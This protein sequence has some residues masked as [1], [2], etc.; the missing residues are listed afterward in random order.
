MTGFETIVEQAAI[1]WFQDLGYDFVTGPTLAPDGEAPERADYKA[2]LLEDRF[3]AALARINPH[4]PPDALEQV[5]R[6]ILRGQTGSLDEDNVAFHRHLIHGVEL[7]VRRG[8]EDRGD[9]AWL[10]DFEHPAKNDWLVVNQL[11]IH[12]PKHNRRP[13]VVVYLNG[14]PIAVLELKNPEDQNA[15]LRSAW[16]QLQTY[17]EQVP[18]LFR[19]N[20]IL[21]LSDGTDAKVGSFTAGFERFG[22]WRTVDGKGLAPDAAPKLEVAIRGL[23]DKAR[24]LDYLRHFI[25]CET[26]DRLEKKIG[27][28]H[29]YWAVNK[30]VAA[31]VR[32]AS[33]KDDHRIGV[34]WHTQG[35]G[36]SISMV[37]YAGKVIREPAMQ[38]PTLVVLTDRNDLDGQLFAQFAAAQDLLRTVPEQATSREH[39][40]ELLKVASGGIVFTTLQKFGTAKGERM[41]E[42]SGR[43]NIVVV[44]DEAHRS[45]Y[46]FV[47]GLARNLRDALPNASFLGFTGT[48]IEADD[49]STAAVFGDYVDTYTISQAVADG[50]TVPIYY[51]ARL[52]RIELP[53]AE[54]P[55]LD[56][57]FDEITE[58]E[59]EATKGKL[60]TNWAKLE[61]VVGAERRVQLIAK[62]IV[63]HWERR[64]EIL[65]GKAMIVGMSRRICVDLYRAIVALRPDWH[66]PDDGAGRIK[67][68][69]T[70][71]ATDPEEFRPHVRNKP[72]QKAIEKRF[73]DPKDDL[74]L[75][76][77][78]DMWLTGFDVP[79]AHTLYLDKPMQGHSLMQAIARVNRVFR[80]KPSGLVVDYLGLAEQLRRAVG[81]YGGRS[82][83]RPG[84]P[85]EEALVVLLEKVEVVKAMLHGHDYRD[86][87]SAK[88][89][90]RVTAL[91][92]AANFVLALH[93]GKIRFLDAMAALNKAAGLALHLE[94]ARHLRDEV[95]LFQAIES[96]LRK[97]AIGGSGKDGEQLDAAIRQIVSGAIASEGVVDVFGAAGLK[98]PDLSILSDEFLETVKDSPHRNLQ[99]ELLKKLLADEIKA[100]SRKNIVQSKKFSEL[101]EKTLLAYQNRTLEAAQVIT[102]LIAMAKTFR[103]TPKRNQELGLTEDELAF[104]DALAA[105]GDVRNVMGDKVLAAIAHDLVKAIRASVTIDWTQRES[106]RAAMR[107]KVKRLLRQH[108]YP[109]DKQELA[110][111]TVIE[112]AEMVCR[113]WS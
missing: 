30:A 59:E 68:V 65:T 33:K 105:H 77:V 6:T 47:E 49:K 112:Q 38:N 103:D 24:L 37:F 36:K 101:L 28:Y 74:E 110:V 91:A 111:V 27:G 96:N 63:G 7:K 26:D 42:L 67:V 71:S 4:L 41:P 97:Y 78:R 5:A 81:A 20:E 89:A 48:P 107:S 39:L 57:E 12:G 18:E 55:R 50:A 9:Q 10:V 94:A 54:K 15:T 45:H 69:M 100:Q 23:F 43:K 95:G 75:V 87:F 106:V 90:A 52:A 22:P 17:R 61:K 53:E 72:A 46:E 66:A 108:G 93:D 92:A 8:T 102:E 70:G 104:Y 44:A 34:I 13:D 60:K 76:I 83:E 21:L 79:C 29:Q 113:E 82:G 32:A 86:Y 3:R 1:E 51:E 84:V 64:R 11:T 99:I 16:R 62:D 98:K 19:T 31:T 85:I 40:R 88:A 35:S 80:D 56:Q 2:V 14:L 58:G 25:L 109:P 73:K